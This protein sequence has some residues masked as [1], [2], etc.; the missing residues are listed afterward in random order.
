MAGRSCQASA[1]GSRRL[2]GAGSMWECNPLCVLDFYVEASARRRG[3]GRALLDCMMRSEGVAH[4]AVLA[5]VR[6][7]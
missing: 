1:R 3:V 7:A 2:G 4:P 5:Y 6:A